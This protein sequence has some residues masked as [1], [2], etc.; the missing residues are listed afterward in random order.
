MKE[1]I[2]LANGAGGSELLKSLAGHGVNSFNLRIFSAIELARYVL[3][4]SGVTVKEGF[5]DATE[6]RVYIVKALAGETYFGKVTYNDVIEISNAIRQMRS[7]SVDEGKIKSILEKGVFQE[8]N[9]AL[10]SVCQKYT[11]LLK[12]D[13]VFDRISFIRYALEN[14]KVIDAEFAVLEEYPASP[15][16]SALLKKASGGNFRT[17][18]IRELFGREELPVHTE[19]I[20]K[21]Y[22]AANEAETI[23]TDIY[24][25]EN[26]QNDTAD[27]KQSNDAADGTQSNG[28]GENFL[29][30]Y[31]VVITD[32]TTYSQLFFDYALLYDI[33]VTF[34]CGIPIMNANPAKLLVDYYHWMTGGFFGEE[35]LK[36]MMNSGVFN[37]R[38]FWKVVSASS[39]N[40]VEKNKTLFFR[41]LGKI[42]FTNNREENKERLGALKE[43]LQ[44]GLESLPEGSDEYKKTKEQ[45]ECIPLLERA[46]EEFSLPVEEF[47][48]KYAFVR[49]FSGKK[50]AEL[51]RSLDRS[52]LEVIYNELKAIRNSGIEQSTDDIIKSVLSHAVCIQSMREGALHVTTVS[53]AFSSIRKNLCIAGL[54]ALKFPGSPKENYLLLDTDLVNFGKE[55]V[56]YTSE[57]RVLERKNQMMKL[58]ELASALDCRIFL[59]YAGLNVAELKRENASS[60]IYEIF[61]KE[62]G[63]KATDEQLEKEISVTGY[64]EP[65]INNGREIG[66]AYNEG[67]S[68][69]PSYIP[70]ASEEVPMPVGDAYSPTAISNY[71]KCARLF[72]LK[73][74]LKIPE[75]R[76]S[77]PFEIMSAADCGILAHSLME[78]LANSD[79]SGQEFL[80]ASYAAFDDY[81]KMHPPLVGVDAGA[82]RY[83]FISMMQ[84]AYRKDPHREVVFAEEEITRLH[85]SGITLT[86]RPDRVEMLEDG[87]GL[88]VDYKTG[89]NMEHKK[90]DAASCLQGLIYAYLMEHKENPVTISGIE[91][92][93]IRTG[94]VIPCVYDE[95]KKREL[96]EILS[97]FKSGMTTGNFPCA[98]PKSE[99]Q[100]GD[101]PCE[102]CAYISV[103]GIL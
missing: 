45:Q 69:V 2:I 74:I 65:K 79:L 77:D 51:L 75:E 47:I 11:Q 39:E 52:A 10:Y 94:D 100:N 17:V 59:S 48:L 4:K 90:D 44:N 82:E 29:D 73:H 42:R 102:N 95:N 40:D 18:C 12:S 35:A 67:K 3:T 21:C 9:K 98:N 7:L 88:I 36:R 20:R 63:E 5:I 99:G 53:K 25:R 103:C 1:R 55:S 49:T 19:L 22:G 85:E 30:K 66:L 31:T 37:R 16:E 38:D 68:I 14:C 97:R 58:V 24:S 8:K 41:L 23:L 89:R 50:N 46:A 60:L 54:S 81:I 91:F 83:E 80:D 87:T 101:S 15:L 96:F 72:A 32:L 61:R 78:R 93:Y 34:G 56:R 64:F 6:E 76:W 84:N 33:P 13:G 28:A 62:Y 71:F 57:G 86:G 92:R 70:P 26:T 43:S 27:E